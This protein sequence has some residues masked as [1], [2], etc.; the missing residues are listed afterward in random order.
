MGID[1]IVDR[2]LMVQVFISKKTDLLR[3]EVMYLKF[4]SDL[5]E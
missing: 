3:G 1:V 4:N 2:L 5:E